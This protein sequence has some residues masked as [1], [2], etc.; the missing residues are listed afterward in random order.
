MSS[1][2]RLK[3]LLFQFHYYQWTEIIQTFGHIDIYLFLIF[4]PEYKIADPICTFLFSILVLCTTFT[5]MRDI[6]LVLM[7]GE[8]PVSSSSSSNNPSSSLQSSADF[9]PVCFF[10]CLADLLLRNAVGGEVQWSEGPF[11]GCEGGHGGPQP[12]HLGSDYEPGDALS[13]CRNRWENIL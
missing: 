5:I 13:T 3:Y 12:S 2:F 8:D 9:P 7:E 1:I 10:L 4:Q 11:A 6:L